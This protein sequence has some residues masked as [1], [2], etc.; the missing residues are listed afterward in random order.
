MDKTSGFYPLDLG[1]TPGGGTKIN[2][3]DAPALY[4]Y[5]FV[6][7]DRSRKAEFS[8]AERARAGATQYFLSKATENIDV[9]WRR[10]LAGAPKLL[11][12]ILDAWR[13]TLDKLVSLFTLLKQIK[14]IG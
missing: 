3:Y 9:S 4:D 2:E 12:R 1:S 13:I 5:Y 14:R 11:T 8:R 7:T 10:L 6:V